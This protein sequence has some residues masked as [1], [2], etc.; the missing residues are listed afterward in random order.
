MHKLFSGDLCFQL[1]L[2]ELFKLLGGNFL[3]D[4]RHHVELFELSRGELSSQ[5]RICKLCELCCWYV[6]AFD[7]FDGVSRVSCWNLPFKHGCDNASELLLMRDREISAKLS[8][9]KL[10]KV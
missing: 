8:F 4:Y 3:S 5:Q 10:W 6:S 9:V 7:G 1:R 2:H